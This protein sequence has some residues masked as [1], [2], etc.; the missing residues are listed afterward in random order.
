VQNNTSNRMGL[1]TFVLLSGFRLLSVFA[2]Q[3]FFCPDE[4]WQSTEIGHKLAFG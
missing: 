2:V 1:T 3:T 4:Y